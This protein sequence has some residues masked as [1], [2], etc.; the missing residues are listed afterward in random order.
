[1]NHRLSHITTVVSFTLATGL[2]MAG[3]SGQPAHAG[4]EVITTNYPASFCQ[5]PQP[6]GN[7]CLRQWRSW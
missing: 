4:T 1:M 5:L 7:H 2:L 6:E 3:L